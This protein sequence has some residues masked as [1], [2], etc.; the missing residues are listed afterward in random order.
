[1]IT[2]ALLL[3]AS[4]QAVTATAVSQNTIDLGSLPRDIGAGEP[5]YLC[6]TVDETVTAAGSATVLFGAVVSDN[7][8]LSSGDT[9]AATGQ[10]PKADLVA[11]R[12]PIFLPIPN[13]NLSANP[14]GKRYFGAN[15]TVGTGPL[16]AGKFTVNVV[17]T[18]QDV[19]KY[20][21]S[22]WTVA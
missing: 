10:I 17:H 11:G 2:D 5:L 8:D 19:S 16:T 14:K 15:F 6:I 18:R 20:Y 12:K 9:L 13:N 7:T 22:G 1:M 21:P 4:A 3:L